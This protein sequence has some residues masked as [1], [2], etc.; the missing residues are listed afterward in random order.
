M[1]VHQQ[2]EF[3][4]ASVLQRV[5]VLFLTQYCWIASHS[6]DKLVSLNP[7][8]LLMNGP[9]L[10]ISSLHVHCINY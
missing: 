4:V 9:H 8:C 1:N 6:R 7:N 5:A 10:K 2:S 3:I